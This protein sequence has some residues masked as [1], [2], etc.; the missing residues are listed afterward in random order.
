MHYVSLFFGTSVIAIA[1][2]LESHRRLH[3]LS[4]SPSSNLDKDYIRSRRRFRLWTNAIIALIGILAAA[5]GFVGRGP[6]WI[7]LWAVIPVFVLAIVVLAISDVIR[8]NSY[9]VRKLPELRAE[10][11]GNSV[12]LAKPENTGDGNNRDYPGNQDSPNAADARND[13]S[14]GNSGNDQIFPQD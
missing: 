3:D 8:T 7:V 12:S 13:G 1:L 5:A 9:L 4:L 11:L 6:V 10:T 14:S 2:G